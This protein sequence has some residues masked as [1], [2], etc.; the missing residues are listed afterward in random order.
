MYNSEIH[1]IKTQFNPEEIRIV[2]FDTT[3]QKETVISEPDSF[4]SIEIIG[5]G[6]TC[7]RDVRKHIEEAK[8]TAAII[9]SDLQCTPMVHLTEDIPVLWIIVNNNDAKV[10][11]GQPIYITT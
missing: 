11:F 8:P 3:I 4:E 9:F 10:S 7:L 6:G 5:R 1:Y 2:Q